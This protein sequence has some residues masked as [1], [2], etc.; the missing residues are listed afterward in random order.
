MQNIQWKNW[1]VII[2]VDPDKVLPGAV[3]KTLSSLA[4]DAV[5][6]GGTQNVTRVNSQQLFDL[7]K[8]CGYRGPVVQ[9]LSSPEAVILGVDGYL[10]PVV[11][12]TKKLLWL[13]D[14]HLQAIEM[15]GD[16]IPWEKV[17]VEGYLVCNPDSAVGQKTG[18]AAVTAKQAAAYVT[19]AERVY[20]LPVFYI[21]YSGIYGDL[22]MVRTISRVRRNI[23]LW[24]GGGIRSTG[25]VRQMLRHVD[26]VVIGN[27][28]YESS[29]VLEEL[30][31]IR[32]AGNA[33]ERNLSDEVIAV[34]KHVCDA[35]GYVYDPEKG[36]PDNGVAPGT[37]FEDLPDTWVCPKCGVETDDFSPV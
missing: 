15:Y 24:Y 6:I 8:S 32:A 22:E 33:K 20:N 12:N 25:Q 3:R 19:L 35:C 37:D 30:V 2:K 18:A 21:E 4:V 11:L 34:Q 7:V 14:A 31:K 26:T 36:E 29:P 9:E 28:I 1:R 17:L 16:L 5:V 23:R 13:R 27:A 10:L